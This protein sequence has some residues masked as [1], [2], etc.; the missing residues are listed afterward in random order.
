MNRRV[1]VVVLGAGY[2]GL[3]AAM[4]LAK[5]TDPGVEITVINATDSFNERV[6]NHQLAAGQPLRRLSVTSLLGGTRVRFVRGTVTALDPAHRR[7]AV[8][9]DGGA[10]S[11]GYDYLIYA[12]GSSGASRGVPGVREHAFTLDHDA[13]HALAH[14]LP[15]VAQRG[16]TA[17]VVGG[18]NTGVEVATELAGAYPGLKVTLATRRSF[19][20]NLSD[21]ARAYI[22]TRFDRCGVHFMEQT[23]IAR[24]DARGALTEAGESIAFDLCVWA[25]GFTVSDLARRSGLRVNARGQI[26]VDRAMRSLSHPEIY[27]VGDAAAPLESPGAPVRMALY[28]ALLMASHGADSLAA[29][30][31]GKPP[32]AFGFSY[33]A[34]GV[35]LGRRDGVVQFLTSNDAPVPFILTGRAA[36]LFREFFVNAALWVIRAQRVAP[37]VFTWPGRNKMRHVPVQASGATAPA[38]ADPVARADAMAHAAGGGGQ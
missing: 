24:L 37:W 36:G 35:S 13:A 17:L 31:A 6:R 10:R 29:H 4:R 12:L 21:A 14:R 25:A 15:A 3:M 2:A 33:L 27:A 18:G 1:N 8:Q 26:L 5:K 20:H 11:L 22:R 28:T 9:A 23:A 30:L 19:A 7:V 32:T 34:L 38:G 16:G